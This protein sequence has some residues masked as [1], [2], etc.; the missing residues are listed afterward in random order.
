MPEV[1][2]SNMNFLAFGWR[3]DVLNRNLLS[4]CQNKENLILKEQREKKKDRGRQHLCKKKK[5]KKLRKR[6]KKTHW[7]SLAPNKLFI[8]EVQVVQFIFPLLLNDYF[9]FFLTCW[10]QPFS[11]H[12]AHPLV[13]AG[14]G[15]GPRDAPAGRDIVWKMLCSF[16]G[17]NSHKYPHQ[18]ALAI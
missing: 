11:W 12:A 9:F 2:S 17:Q 18:R 8:K 14:Q 10:T 6:L 15:C 13:E 7:N 4:A 16:E 1:R 5:K 3:N